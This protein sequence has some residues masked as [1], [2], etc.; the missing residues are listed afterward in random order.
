MPRSV[1]PSAIRLA[2]RLSFPQ[3]KQCAN[4]ANAVGVPAG[5]SSSAESFSPRALG[6]SKR[7]EGMA[8]SLLRLRLRDRHRFV[9]WRL[10]LLR[11]LGLGLGM[12]FFVLP[13]DGTHDVR[14][15]IGPDALVRVG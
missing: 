5:R 8:C 3:V 12:R 11:L 14:I 4:S 6:K 13:E 15:V 2:A 10:G 7:S 1:R 9:L